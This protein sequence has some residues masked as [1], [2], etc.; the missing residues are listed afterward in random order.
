MPSNGASI[1]VGATQR[2][3]RQQIAAAIA[4]LSRADMARV[5]SIAKWL[6][7]RCGMSAE[8]LSQEAYLRALDTR[9]CV[10]GTE[11]VPF[12]K[13]IMRSITS[14]EPRSRRRAREQCGLEIVYVDDYD[15][16]AMS[17]PVDDAPSPEDAA[18]SSAFHARQIARV[19]AAIAHDEEL[20]LLVVGRHR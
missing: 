16:K 19:D 15:Q 7:F 5:L 18:L 17:Q 1:A 10:V 20:Q 12:L 9:T 2:Y 11:M 13:G 14:E 3:T 8:Y 4:A 6:G